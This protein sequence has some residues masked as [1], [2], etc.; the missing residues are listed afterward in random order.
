MLGTRAQAQT[1]VFILGMYEPVHEHD[2]AR[3]SDINPQT[4]AEGYGRR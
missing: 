3:F 4:W 2:E 1:Q